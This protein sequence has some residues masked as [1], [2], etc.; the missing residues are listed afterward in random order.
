MTEIRKNVKNIFI[1]ANFY[2]AFHKYIS[3]YGI[4]VYVVVE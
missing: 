3:K 2:T 1:K 4:A